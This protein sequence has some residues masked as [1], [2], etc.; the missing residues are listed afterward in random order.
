MNSIVRNQKEQL[1]ELLDS[2]VSVGIII[3]ENQ[4]I[5]TVG[6]SLALYLALQAEGKNVQIVSKKEPIVE[7]SNLVGIDK[8]GKSFD[9]DTRILT[10]SV[11]NLNDEIEKVSYNIE[12]DR[13]KVNLF[14][15]ERG[16]SFS[17]RDI[18]YIKKGSAPAL[19]ITV[20]VS[21]ES[22]I[23]GLVD[24]ASVKTIHISNNSST[25]L[26]GDIVIVDPAFTSVSEIVSELFMD[27]SLNDVDAVQNLMDGITFATRNFSMPSTSPFAFEAAGFLLQ[28]GA[29]RREKDRN[30]RPRRDSFPQESHFLGQN[31]NRNQSRGNR[32][33]NQPAGGQN[34]N[35]NRNNQQSGQNQPRNVQNIINELRNTPSMPKT[36]MVNDAME[37]S[38]DNSTLPN[39]FSTN[40]PAQDDN[41]FQG[42]EDLTPKPIKNADNSLPADIPEDWFL[43]KVFKGSKKNNN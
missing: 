20:G 37:E 3:G 28:N 25:S 29:K 34:Q 21:N 15:E 7:V 40:F 5:D 27:L 11:P 42:Q 33:N 26:G 2:V 38:F 13:L 12:G 1:R 17:E 35:R 10:I 6:A 30:D 9:G 39:D 22:E 16:I 36:D 4:N 41:S 14:A 23:T 32:P 8:V 19:I 24:L 31:D 43:P 18:E